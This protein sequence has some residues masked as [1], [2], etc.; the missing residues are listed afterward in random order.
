M[1]NLET[2]YSA[3]RPYS[4]EPPKN[5][6]LASMPLADY[7]RLAPILRSVSIRARQ[8]LHKQGEPIR[9]VYF[10]SSGV[11]ALTKTMENGQTA[12]VATV[13]NEGVIGT[14]AFFGDGVSDSDTLVQL[15][16]GDA[17]AMPIDMF[18][19]E[20]TRHGAF[21]NIVI[22]Y[23]QALVSQIM[24]TTG[25]NGLHS[26]RHRCSRW[27]LTTRDRVNADEFPLTHE[28]LAAML[29]VRRPTITIVM[30][31]LQRGE[32]IESRRGSVKIVNRRGLEAASCE[33]YRT[34]NA[35]FRRLMPDVCQ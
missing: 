26:V 9:E 30:K 8:R 31:S 25:C 17:L 3:I 7:D 33:C 29:G 32:L 35:N 14:S 16:D 10:P 23:S 18:I 28:F 12:Q 27:L 24:Q 19:E 34:V 22:R 21:F 6:L 2:T 4:S 13:G 15:S 11:W 1:Q 20:M 5:R